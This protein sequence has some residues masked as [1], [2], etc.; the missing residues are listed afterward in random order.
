MSIDL[1]L[2]Y[3]VLGILTLLATAFGFFFNLKNKIELVKND[4][5]NTKEQLKS[6][7]TKTI[8][9]YSKIE[10]KISELESKAEDRHKDLQT[11]IDKMP[12]EILNLFNTIKGSD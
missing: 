2:V 8:A 5:I 6:L 3:T 12:L 1:Q 11:R 9:D 7:E 10:N 4:L